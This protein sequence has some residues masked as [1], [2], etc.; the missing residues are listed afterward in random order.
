MDLYP[1]GGTNISSGLLMAADALENKTGNKIIVLLT[2]GADNNPNE[3]PDAIKELQREGIAVYSI[4]FGS[5][6]ADYLENISNQTGGQLMYAQNPED[7]Q[8][9]YRIINGFISNDYTFTFKTSADSDELERT[10]K[11]I[12]PD[13]YYDEI[14]YT[15][16]L[17]KEE[18]DVIINSPPRSDYYQQIG[19]SNKNGGAY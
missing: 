19:G 5:A 16:G 9:M 3:M 10:V 15:V 8:E 13:G 7:L 11:I 2:D 14:D 1:G 4:G 12:M 17:S 6:E 18:I